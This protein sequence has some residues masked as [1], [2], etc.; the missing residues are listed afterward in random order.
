MSTVQVFWKNCGEKEKFL[1]TSNFS[2]SHSVFYPFGKLFS[3]FI[4]FE[5]VMYKLFQ[6]VS[7]WNLLFVKGV[8]P[9]SQ[10]L[11]TQIEKALENLVEKEKNQHFLLFLQCFLPFQ[12]QVPSLND[13]QKLF[14]KKTSLKLS[15]STEWNNKNFV[16]SLSN[17]RFKTKKWHLITIHHSKWSQRS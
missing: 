15:Y 9:P 16:S 17:K 10:A 12:K 5:I 2:F 4:K 1:L 13:V 3:F 14:S 6:F 7:L 11:I 8:N